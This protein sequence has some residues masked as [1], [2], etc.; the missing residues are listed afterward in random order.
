M[1]TNTKTKKPGK[2]SPEEIRKKEFEAAVALIREK[3][4]EMAQSIDE[5]I[6]FIGKTYADKYSKS[7][8]PTK[9]LIYHHDDKAKGYNMGQAARYISRYLT[10]GFAKSDN[11]T[12]LKKCLHYLFFELTRLIRL[13]KVKEKAKDII[14]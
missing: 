4:P 12:D 10:D 11:P 5:A 1:A 14:E 6:I 3:E 8:I 13:D 9:G 2:L 7:P